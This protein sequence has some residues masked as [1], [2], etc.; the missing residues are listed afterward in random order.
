MKHV[1]PLAKTIE[2]PLGLSGPCLALSY[3]HVNELR[4]RWPSPSWKY[5]YKGR[6]VK[7]KTK[8][9]HLVSNHKGEG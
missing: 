5:Y 7:P 4:L 9:E 2:K 3:L 8:H 1:E 6:V